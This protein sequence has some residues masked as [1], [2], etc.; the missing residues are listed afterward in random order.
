MR[1]LIAT[2]TALFVLHLVDLAYCGG[3]Y[4]KAAEMVIHDVAFGIANVLRG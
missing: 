3:R 1:A 4:S 2:C